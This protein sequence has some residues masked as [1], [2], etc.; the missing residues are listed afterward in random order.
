MTP[1]KL[2]SRSEHHLS[3]YHAPASLR[4]RVR[5]G[6]QSTRRERGTATVVTDPLSV[7]KHLS[8]IH[9]RNVGGIVSLALQ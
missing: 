6:A 7:S 3:D 5:P 4:R 9:R 2:S 8:H 1:A